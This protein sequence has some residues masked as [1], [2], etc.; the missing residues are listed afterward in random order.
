MS[1]TIGPLARVLVGALWF[2]S[3]AVLQ[4]G[5]LA[6]RPGGA[7]PGFD[8]RSRLGEE[9]GLSGGELP[10]SVSPGSVGRGTVGTLSLTLE[11]DVFADDDNNY[12]SGAG[13]Q[14]T[15]A[16]AETYREGSFYRGVVETMSFLPF[17][18]DAD[19]THFSSLALSHQIYTPTDIED[20]DPPEDDQPYAGLL[21]LNASLASR[22][23]RSQHEYG[24]LLGVIG[25]A[26]RGEQIQTFTHELVRTDEPEAWDTQLANE[27]LVNLSYAYHRRL[28][29]PR[30]G[31]GLDADVSSS[32]FAEAGTYLT[33]A[34]GGVSVRAGFKLPDGYSSFGIQSGLRPA[35]L[36]S[37]RLPDGWGGFLFASLSGLGVAHFAPHGNLFS[38]GRSVDTEPFVGSASLGISVYYGRFL[39]TYSFTGQTDAFETQRDP[40]EY[41]ALSISYAF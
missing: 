21:H 17:V 19:R 20:P 1:E 4:V 5:C 37:D 12:T 28:V 2:A 29:P 33:G 16:P 25:P 26:A 7:D 11:N 23:E 14:W 18:G 31:S 3:T 13:W 38:D 36:P 22:G 10:E 15:S 41:G 34:G 8:S 24:V 30:G 32:L 39:F 9:T 40:T 35:S 6:P 27:P